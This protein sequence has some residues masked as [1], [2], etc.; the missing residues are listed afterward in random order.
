MVYAINFYKNKS[1]G[2]RKMGVVV[3]GS[4]LVILILTKLMGG[5]EVKDATLISIVLAK[6]S[7]HSPILSYPK[8]SSVS[9]EFYKKTPFWHKPVA[10][11]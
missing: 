7:T 4:R 11:P 9:D 10:V 5:D 3:V 6:I 8:S 1:R 2:K